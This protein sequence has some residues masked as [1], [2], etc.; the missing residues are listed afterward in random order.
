V[1]DAIGETRSK[2][3][4]M[5]PFKGDRSFRDTTITYLKMLNSV[6]NEDYGKIVNMEEIAEQSYDAMEAYMTAKEQAWSKLGI[7]QEKQHE[8]EKDFAKKNNVTL[9][10][11]ETPLSEKSKTAS[12]VLKHANAVYL[13][14]FKS[15]KQ[16]SYFMEALDKK[17][18]VAL[19]QNINTLKKYSEE[20]MEKLKQMK[21]YNEDASLIAACHTALAF[22]KSESFKASTFTDF[23]VKEESFEKIKKLFESKPE[24]KRTQKDVDEYNKAVN[25]MNT[26]VHTYNDVNQELNKERAEVLK[27]WNNTYDG[28]LSQYMPRQTKQ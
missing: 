4:G 25:D 11:N 10:D 17:N 12:E 1:V 22:Y 9:I 8:T 21:G 5:P 14:F 27:Q 7:A 20:G 26:A 3:S 19:D 16:E 6:F 13:I 23:M 2:I 18:M 28:Y 15:Y 24:S